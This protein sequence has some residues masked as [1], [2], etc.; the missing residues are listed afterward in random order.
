LYYSKFIYFRVSVAKARAAKMTKRYQI[1]ISST[2]L[3]L[4]QE[5]QIVAETITNAYHIPVGMELFPA[6]QDQW[7]MIKE[8]IDNSDYYVLIV[9]SRYGSIAPV[10]P[11]EE[12]K[13]ISYTQKEY[14][15]AYSKGIPIYTFF[16]NEQ[17]LI[18]ND[19]VDK[20]EKLRK[21]LEIFKRT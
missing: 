1:F 3:D 19:K 10:L 9:A 21:K 4:K 11:G 2:Y 18:P 8:L 12:K 17:E 13:E 14:E 16:R 5:R 7:E 6:S 15:Y 20:I